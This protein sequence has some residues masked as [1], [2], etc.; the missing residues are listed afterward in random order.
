MRYLSNKKLE[1]RIFKQRGE[2]YGFAGLINT[3][4]REWLE[5]YR[6]CNQGMKRKNDEI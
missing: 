6:G 2:N 1:G 5:I 4:M 3:T